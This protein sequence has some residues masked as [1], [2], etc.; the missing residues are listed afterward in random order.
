MDEL[1]DWIGREVFI[2]ERDAGVEKAFPSKL[3]K[4]G[5]RGVVLELSKTTKAEGPFEGL[6]EHVEGL[7]FIPWLGIKGLFTAPTTSVK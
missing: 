4:A 6:S 3:V 5:S 7:A 2:V 1:N